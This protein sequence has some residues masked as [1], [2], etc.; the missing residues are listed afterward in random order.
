MSF[1]RDSS[2]YS[3]LHYAVRNT[4]DSFAV[5]Q[6]LLHQANVNATTPSGLSTPLHRAAFCGALQQRRLITMEAI[7][8]KVLKKYLKLFIK[9]FKSDNFS[10]SLLKG[11]G[12]LVDLDL[13][14]NVIQE[15][16][17]LPPQLRVISATC[18]TLVAK[19]P[20]TSYKKEPI[21]MSMNSINIM[22]KEPEV[23][24][25]LQPQFKKFK[26]KN[27]N[28]RNEVTENL[29][30]EVKSL[31]LTI[32]TMHGN[33]LIVELEDVLVQSTNSNFQFSSKRRIK[34]WVQLSAKIEFLLTSLNLS[35]TLSQWH[36]ISDLF[37]GFQSILARHAPPPLAITAEP[38][39]KKKKEK[40]KPLSASASLAVHSSGSSPLSTSPSPIKKSLDSADF[41]Q[42]PA[43]A[44]PKHS[45]WKLELVDNHTIDASND[46][47]FIFQGDGLH[48]GFTSSNVT[49]KPTNEHGEL[50]YTLPIRESIVSVVMNALRIQEI[51]SF[52]KNTV[53]TDMCGHNNESPKPRDNRYDTSITSISS[54]G[55]SERMQ[56]HHYNGPYLLKGNMIFRRPIVTDDNP[57]PLK[58]LVSADGKPLPPLIGLELNLHLS[59]LKMLGDRR[60]WKRLISFLMPPEVDE[61]DDSESD[62]STIDPSAPLTNGSSSL[63]EIP[64]DANIDN[65]NNPTAGTNGINGIKDPFAMKKIVVEKGKKKISSFKK[66]LKLGDN[67]KNQIKI[68]LKATETQV[69][70]PEESVTIE[71]F[72]GTSMKVNLGAFVMR[73]HS[74]WKSVPHLYEGLQMIDPNCVPEPITQSGLDHRFSFKME[75]ISCII[76][77]SNNVTSIL[78]PASVCLYLRVSKSAFLH[79]EKRIPKIDLSFISSDFN[80]RVTKY[81]TN[82]L[83]FIAKKYLS[84][85]KM[86]GLLQSRI[87]SIKSATKKRLNLMKDQHIDR[88]LTI[89]NKVEK[90]LQEY[91]WNVYVCIQKGV[92]YLPLQ[93][94][95]E[96]KSQ[97]DEVHFP[98]FVGSDGN[99][100][101]EF[102]VEQ[103]GIALQNKAEGQ[104]IVFKVGTFEATGIEHPKLTTS[105]TLRPLPI[106]EDEAIPSQLSD[107]TNLL[108]TY[109]RHQKKL[110]SSL[111]AVDGEIDEWVADVLVRLQGTQVQVV[112]KPSASSKNAS[113]KKV[114]GLKIPDVQQF[115]TKLVN[116][117]ESKKQD[118]DNLKKGIKKVK[119][120][121]TWGIE[122]GNCEILMGNKSKNMDFIQP[123]GRI[124]I[125]D[126]NR[127][128]NAKAYKD[129]EQEL[130]KKTMDSAKS[131]MEKDD[132][133]E[134]I[135][136]L[137]EE[138][139]KLKK[140]N[141]DELL[142]LKTE[143]MTLESKFVQTKMA[144]AEMEDENASLKHDL[145]R[146]SKK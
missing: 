137:T 15:L 42:S 124:R 25:P 7:V 36:L 146:F 61:T 29:Q 142:T 119:L 96:P 71:E 76:N 32:A 120:G 99:A 41:T 46:E 140:Q 27:K 135:N 144:M 92:F 114:P 121:I 69:I 44:T 89:K 22:L 60:A 39:K 110:N 45:E 67:W 58:C 79:K 64:S 139:E 50:L 13:N 66:K 88:T 8:L 35:W 141:N 101:S 128:I 47:G 54:D 90:T 33:S 12:Q 49:A 62:G 132:Y 116:T 30:V 127:K 129:I 21:T 11:E 16:L 73:N 74:D 40:E 10:L 100:L 104:N 125:T 24:T 4:S 57:D 133:N 95:L 20:W 131:E 108:V 112:K 17:L 102:K 34:D 43:E 80:I 56:I 53:K 18:D 117:L 75:N 97:V 78:E 2:G 111:V 5:Q 6:L 105:T 38:T 84:P 87:K 1:E 145:K 138:L 118:I 115:I 68:I 83:D 134:K 82:Y 72:K 107:S 23:I 85:K 3:P 91:Y 81:Q 77:Q 19:V 98:D 123:K 9:N 48:F 113:G 143:Y 126:T 59:H 106:P 86:K 94:L 28:K 55:I 63:Q 93:H 122:L 52:A 37:T 103:L 70:I 14:E 31:K 51:G 130:L 26:K 65:N 109:K 136:A